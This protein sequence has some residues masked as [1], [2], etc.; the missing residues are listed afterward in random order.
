MTILE[1]IEGISFFQNESIGI[2]PD[3][4]SLKGIFAYLKYLDGE[5]TSRYSLESVAGSSGFENIIKPA[6]SSQSF[7]NTAAGHYDISVTFTGLFLPT[8][9]TIVNANYDGVF[10]HSFN[11]AWKLIGVD[12]SHEVIL[13][14]QKGIEFCDGKTLCSNSVIKTFKVKNPKAHRTL[15]LRADIGSN[16]EGYNYFIVRYI[17]FFGILFPPNSNGPKLCRPT[18]PERSIFFSPKFFFNLI[19][20]FF[21]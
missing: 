6:D 4:N 10:E 12:N 17:E 15:I 20:I 9:Y 5:Y 13:D 18:I 21:S 8:H 16:S 1:P 11:K 14:H 2:F 7:Y 19:M 3:G